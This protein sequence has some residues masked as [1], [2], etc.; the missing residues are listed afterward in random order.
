MTASPAW[1]S[2]SGSTSASTSAKRRFIPTPDLAEDSRDVEVGD[3][4]QDAVGAA[5]KAL[6]EPYAS[7]MAEGTTIESD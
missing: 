4:P 3:T 5:L 7:E 2:T 6:G 1:I